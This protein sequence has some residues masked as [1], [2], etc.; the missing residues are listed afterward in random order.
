MSDAIRDDGSEGREIDLVRI[1]L[2]LMKSGEG[3]EPPAPEVVEIWSEFLDRCQDL[4][5]G[6]VAR[7]ARRGELEDMV[8]EIWLRLLNK[9]RMEHLVDPSRTWAWLTRTIRNDL[10]DLLKREQRRRRMQVGDGSTLENVKDHRPAMTDGWDDHD[11]LDW[12]LGRLRSETSRLTWEVVRLRLAERAS[13]EE[14]RRR[15]EISADQAKTRFHR[16]YRKL[17]R[18]MSESER[19]DEL[20]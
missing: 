17:L 13:L 20:F 5:R 19:S 7:R 12:A 1:R 2:Y 6:Q 16:G 4:V 3:G 18:I 14:I 8:Q 15:L 9:L 10:I 11:Q